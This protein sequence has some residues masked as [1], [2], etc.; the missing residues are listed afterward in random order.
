MKKLKQARRKKKIFII[1]KF[2]YE[3][4]FLIGFRVCEIPPK[5]FKEYE[6]PIFNHSGFSFYYPI[7]EKDFTRATITKY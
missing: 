5:Y 2:K 6:K 1:K 3:H 7:D 4:S